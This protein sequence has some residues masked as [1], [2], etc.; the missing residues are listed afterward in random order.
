MMS[1][2]DKI[3]LVITNH[4]YGDNF[5]PRIWA[6]YL[7]T[8]ISFANIP[9]FICWTK[10]LYLIWKLNNNTL[11]DFTINSHVE[12]SF[13]LSIRNCKDVHPFV[14]F[15]YDYQLPHLEFDKK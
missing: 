6:E 4:L 13:E 3:S 12:C 11:T 7:I 1:L 2:C 10:D 8:K 9:R 15:F 14:F 5:L